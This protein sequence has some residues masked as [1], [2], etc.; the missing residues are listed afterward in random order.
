MN[1]QQI[2]AVWL[3]NTKWLVAYLLD[4]V[5]PGVASLLWTM[6][7]LTCFSVKNIINV[8]TKTEKRIKYVNR[9]QVTREN[10][11]YILK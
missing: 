7:L 8:L 4:L 3:I 9:L 6:P 11:V 5:Y 2:L 1:H 10:S